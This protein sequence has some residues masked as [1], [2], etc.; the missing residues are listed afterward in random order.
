MSNGYGTTLAYGTDA[1]APDSFDLFASPDVQ[2]QQIAR[3]QAQGSRLEQQGAYNAQ[4]A[5]DRQGQL[6][7]GWQGAQVNN[8]WATNDQHQ[9][10]WA[11][12]SLGAA[13]GQYLHNYANAA[14]A[15]Y[16]Q[17]ALQ[18]QNAQLAMARSTTGGSLAQAS[19]LRGA[20]MQGAMGRQHTAS[21]LASLSIQQQEQGAQLAGQAYQNYAEGAGHLGQF[22]QQQGYEQAGLQQQQNALNQATA[23]QAWG[24]G[25]Q[26][27]LAQLQANL[28]GKGMAVNQS[29]FN[30]N[31]NMN[32]SMGYIGALS[33]LG[34]YGAQAFGSNNNQQSNN[35]GGGPSGDY[36]WEGY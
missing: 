5:Y 6:A 9:A 1:T 20:G 22:N 30:S 12:S 28:A 3:I 26:V 18:A 35:G 15:Q 11:L 32:Q 23:N 25:E 29:M 13:P 36:A 16:Q 2:R 17:Q 34:A 10:D 21:D 7:L 19:A 31:M 8:P 4:D 33:S 14:D 27:Q 24:Q